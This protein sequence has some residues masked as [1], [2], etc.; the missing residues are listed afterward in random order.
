M[1]GTIVGP[2]PRG[3][4]PF[5]PVGQAT[6]QGAE[7]ELTVSTVLAIPTATYRELGGYDEAMTGYGYEDMEFGIRVAAAGVPAVHLSDV[8]ALHVW[9]AKHDWDELSVQNERNL[10]Y[11]LRKHGPDSTSD[12]WANWS[13]WWHYHADREG[14]LVRDGDTLWAVDRGD[15]FKL[16]LPSEEWVARL[17][18]QADDVDDA[19]AGALDELRDAGVAHEP[20]GASRAVLAHGTRDPRSAS[21]SPS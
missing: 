3:L 19:D 10:D 9:H 15:R 20:E 16:A 6:P 1:D 21:V 17:G 18:F 7:P 4:E 11:V 13:V 12:E 14:R 8:Y 2:D 5:L